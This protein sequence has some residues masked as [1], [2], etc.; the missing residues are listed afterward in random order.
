MRFLITFSLAMAL[1]KPVEAKPLK[2]APHIVLHTVLPD[3]ARFIVSNPLDKAILARFECVDAFSENWMEFPKHTTKNVVLT[4]ME[5]IKGPCS[6][7]WKM[8][9]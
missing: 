1:T 9:R 2:H 7:V 6:L 3:G 8:A 4:A 5:P